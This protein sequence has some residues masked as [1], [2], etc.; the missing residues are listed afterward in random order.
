MGLNGQNCQRFHCAKQQPNSH[1]LDTE[2]SYEVMTVLLYAPLLPFRKFVVSSSFTNEV[3]TSIEQDLNK[4]KENDTGTDPVRGQSHLCGLHPHYHR[5][6]GK[7]HRLTWVHAVFLHF[8]GF[9]ATAALQEQIQQAYMSSVFHS[10][11]QQITDLFI[12]KKKNKKQ[13]ISCTFAWKISIFQVV[14][15]EKWSVGM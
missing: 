12:F 2:T 6:I 1:I 13:P 3:N 15:T 14:T 8:T 5:D 7:A 9:L 10:G 4:K 11:L